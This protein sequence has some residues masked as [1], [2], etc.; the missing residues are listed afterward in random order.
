MCG[1]QAF[2]CYKKQNIC[3]FNFNDISESIY[4]ITHLFYLHILNLGSTNVI[5]VIPE[6]AICYIY[7]LILCVE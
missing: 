7:F 3:Y 6:I 4:S 1:I 2:F 5:P